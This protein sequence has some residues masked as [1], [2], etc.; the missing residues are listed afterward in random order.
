MP[1]AEVGLE[2]KLVA[3][4][5]ELTQKQQLRTEAVA[6]ELCARC[7]AAWYFCA[8]STLAQL[9]AI[10]A[11]PGFERLQVLALETEGAR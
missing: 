4:E 2:G 8:R 1:D 7:A 3:V 6:R 5:V 9:E 11:R 10:A